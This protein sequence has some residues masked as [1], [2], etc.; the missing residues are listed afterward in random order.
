MDKTSVY[1]PTSDRIKTL[2]QIYGIFLDSGAN[3]VKKSPYSATGAVQ[4]GHFN[5]LVT[6]DKYTP[7]SQ[8][9]SDGNKSIQNRLEFGLLVRDVIASTLNPLTIVFDGGKKVTIKGITDAKFLGLGVSDFALIQ[10][11]K[12]T[13]ISINM[14]KGNY[15]HEIQGRYLELVY[16]ALETAATEEIL[17]ADVDNNNHMTLFSPLI[18]ESDIR[19]TRELM[20]DDI[21]GGLG[22]INNFEPSQFNYNGKSN[23]LNIKV[24]RVYQTVSDLKSPDKPYFMITSGGTSQVGELKGLQLDLVPKFA[25]PKNTTTVKI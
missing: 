4:V 20:F 13:P 18:F 21:R 7:K 17:D 22:V 9:A 15:R 11:T 2:R 25:L 6:R 5:I 1:V 3:A 10:G 14:L 8:G 23:T 19:S 12:K 16:A 24:N